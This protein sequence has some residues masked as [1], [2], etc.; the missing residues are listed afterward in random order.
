ML[1]SRL[2]LNYPFKAIFGGL[3]QRGLYH[4]EGAEA[5]EPEAFPPRAGGHHEKGSQRCPCLYRPSVPRVHISARG[6]GGPPHSAVFRAG[7]RTVILYK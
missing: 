5:S 2:F 4:G 6:G 1:K 3:E 7:D